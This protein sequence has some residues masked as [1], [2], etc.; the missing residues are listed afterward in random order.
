LDSI[1]LLLRRW[2]NGDKEELYDLILSL[3]VALICH[4]DYARERSSLI[5]YSGVRGYNVEYKQWRQPQDYTTILAGV[6]FCI[7]IIMLERA[8]P[9]VE[10]DAFDENSVMNPVE[11]FCLV[12]NKWLI[13]GESKCII[14]GTNYRYSIW[15]Y[16]PYVE[17]WDCCKQECYYPEQNTMVS[18]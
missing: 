16:T 13:D 4:S 18:R 1:Q 5:Y 3:S 6:Q 14:Y 7:R 12:R 8:L 17:L 2:E 15:I 9:R 11:Q 10:R